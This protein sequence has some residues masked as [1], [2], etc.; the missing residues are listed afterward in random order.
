[1][2]NNK[3]TSTKN[4]KKKTEQT[5]TGPKDARSEKG[6]AKYPNQHVLKTRSG[7]SI[8]YDDSK[9]NESMTIQHRGG[10]CIMFMPDGAVHMTTHNGRYDI[11]FGEDRMTV[12]GAHDITVKGDGSLRVYG[13][14]R[15]TVHGNVEVSATGSITYRGNNINHLASGNHTIVAELGNH[16][17]G[18]AAELSAPHVSVV[19]SDSAAFVG[20]DKAFFGGKNAEVAGVNKLKVGSE[21]GEMHVHTEKDYHQNIRGSKKM[22]I[23]ASIELNVEKDENAEVKGDRNQKIGG[24]NVVKAQEIKLQPS[25]DPKKPGEAEEHEVNS[26]QVETASPQQQN[27]DKLR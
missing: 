16:K 20:R 2:A 23:E 6:A 13:D 11:V 5:W 25:R 19:G 14:Y 9:D 15:K 7:H 18:T 3:K 17:F 24:T 22:K 1:M 27:N 26:N 12:T 10:S 8:I 21:K 4:D